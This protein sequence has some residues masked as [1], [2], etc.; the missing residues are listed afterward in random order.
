MTQG[1][2]RVLDRPEV[3][4]VIAHELAHI[5]NRDTLIM[6]VAATLSGALSM[7]ANAAMW[8][9]LFGGAASSEE[10]EGS[11]PMTGLLGV[12]VAPLAA[13]LVQMSISRARQFM[14]DEAAARF[15]GTPL[16]MASALRKI[17]AASKVVPLDANPAT[18]E[19]ARQQTGVSICS[20]NYEDIV[21]RDDVHAVIIATPNAFH[22]PVA[23]AAA[24][25]GKHVL[26]EK[27]LA[28]NAADA[29]AMADA[30]EKA[31]VRHMTAEDIYKI[32]LKE[33]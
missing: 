26:S 7:L 30:A 20:T 21:K 2:L 6:S 13:T 4:S 3:A 27:P 1:L 16:A 12:L 25:A 18:L 14:A 19:T 17:E 5:R 24:R 10:E 9:S 22:P 28:L 23:I 11:H 29:H 33:D 8:G 15:T 32:L 31:K